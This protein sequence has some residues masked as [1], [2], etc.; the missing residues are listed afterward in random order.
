M[1]LKTIALLLA[2]LVVLALTACG[3]AGGGASLDG[4]SW[5]LND[6]NGSVPIA[7]TLVTAKFADGQVSGNSGCNTYGGSYE[8]NGDALTVSALFMTEM[9]CLDPAGAM[10]QESAYLDILGRAA[11]YQVDGPQLTITTSNGDTLTFT[12]SS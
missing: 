6:L 4:T 11:S 5:T 10:D 12:A 9:A 2:G 8:V 7:G 1:K 3:G